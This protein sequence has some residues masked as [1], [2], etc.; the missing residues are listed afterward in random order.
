MALQRRNSPGKTILALSSISLQQKKT[1]V[2]VTNEFHPFKM[3]LAVLIMV[4][5]LVLL[6]R[7]LWGR[8]RK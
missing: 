7:L 5:T 1:I 3:H 6:F 2:H 4:R 8:K